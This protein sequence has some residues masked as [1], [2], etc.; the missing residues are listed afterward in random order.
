MWL[1]PVFVFFPVDGHYLPYL[2]MDVLEGNTLGN[3]L[4]SL[5]ELMNH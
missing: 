5:H 1:D 3:K 4:G 2:H